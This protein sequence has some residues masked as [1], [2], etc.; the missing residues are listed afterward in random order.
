ML[1]AIA[2]LPVLYVAAAVTLPLIPVNRDAP[3]SEAGITVFVQSGRY[4]TELV[5]PL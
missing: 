2:L 4:H 3:L 5:V 1:K